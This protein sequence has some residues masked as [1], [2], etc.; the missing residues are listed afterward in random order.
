MFGISVSAPFRFGVALVLTWVCQLALAQHESSPYPYVIDRF[1]VQGVWA[2]NSDL[3]VT[4][5]IETTFHETR[6]G[7]FRKIPINFDTGRGV[8]RRTKIDKIQ[9]VDEQGAKHTTKISREGAYINI[10]I[11]D[12]DIE[13]PPGTRKTYV[14]SYRV[15]NATNWFDKDT[16]WDAR[17]ELYWN[18]TGN[19]WDTEIRNFSYKFEFPETAKPR[20]R[21]ITGYFGSTASVNQNGIG[22]A[23]VVNAADTTLRLRSSTLAGER[24]SP[25]NPG[26]GVTFVLNVPE[27]VMARPGIGTQIY[28]LLS[29]NVGLLL[30]FA[31]VL[32]LFPVWLWKGR[33]PKGHKVDVLFEPPDGLSATACGSLLD[34]RVDVKD[35]SAG[36]ITLAVRGYLTIDAKEAGLFGNRDSTIK[37]TGKQDD[38]NLPEFEALLLKKLR[39]G[40]AEISKADLT[41]YVGTNIGDLQ[42]EAYQSL[43]KRGYYRTA[44]NEVK[45]AGCAIGVGLAVVMA[46]LLNVVFSMGADEGS[47]VIGVFASFFV[48]LLFSLLLPRRTQKGADTRCQVAAFENAMRGRKDYLEWVADKKI[49]DAKYEEYLPY[50]IAFGLVQQW[51]DTFKDVVSAPPAWYSS[52]HGQAHWTMNSFTSDFTNATTSLGYAA[53]TPP[54]TSSSSGSSGFSSGGSSGGGFGGGGGGSW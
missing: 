1:S 33:D 42:R 10:R 5:R 17:A 32:V 3:E 7:I 25:L 22:S 26:E 39:Q 20:A 51:S 37:L 50:A 34:D 38:G 48:V 46:I 24:E 8:A 15:Q 43:V 47:W 21:V 19:D 23:S 4:E 29:A 31:L 45:A 18:M 53:N 28:W 44:P 41:T 6:H 12:K 14:V 52:P 36:L 54:R 40:G 9:V 35:V 11:G 13:L 16:E 2:A 30:P 27:T 49:A